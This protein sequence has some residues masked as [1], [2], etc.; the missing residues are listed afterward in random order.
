MRSLAVLAVALGFGAMVG[1]GTSEPSWNETRTFKF[2][3]YTIQPEDDITDQC[4]Q[5][6]LNNDSDIYISTVTLKT[7]T[8][9]HH[10]NWFWVP[11]HEF[12]GPHWNGHNS[13]V[14]DGTFT[15]VDRNF[16]QAVA[17]LFG[18]V[19]FAQS[20]QDPMEVQQFPDGDVIKIPAHSKLVST[21]HLL[22]PGDS[23]LSLKPTIAL[24]PVPEDQ[25]TTVLAGV[26]FENES[27]ALPPNAQSEF[28]VE[29]DLVAADQPP[30]TPN[31]P[32]PTFKLYHALAHYHSLGTGMDIEAVKA[33]GTSTSIFQT[34]T[35]I[36]DS[37]GAMLDPPFDFTGYAKIRF[38]CDYYNSTNG[39]VTW[40][41]ELTSEMCVFLAFSDSPVD[42]AGGV[43]DVESPGP[44]TMVGDVYTYSHPC[45][46]VATPA[47]E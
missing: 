8:G 7:G 34:T 16:D 37:L 36:G 18:G 9:M 35:Q 26:S 3:P 4:V 47:N 46:V 12:P 14:D 2:G 17:A 32:A 42:W 45:Y 5:I 39:T 10:S 30:P 44:P 15:C 6:T 38:T 43:T 22:N 28:S 13:S 41:Q 21:I 31:W 1:C 20:T 23:T 25:V 24:T 19:V 33:D 29:C 11:E 27:I 40:G